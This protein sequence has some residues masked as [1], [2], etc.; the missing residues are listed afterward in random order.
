MKRLLVC[1]VSL[2]VVGGCDST[3]KALG[4]KK[5]V[6]DEHTLMERPPL[7]TPKDLYSLRPPQ[8]GDPEAAY[9]ELRSAEGKKAAETAKLSASERSLLKSA[10]ASTVDTKASSE[11]DSE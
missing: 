2:V 7:T 1:L 8:S 6:P 9:R 5:V 11:S 4:L 3:K 10:D